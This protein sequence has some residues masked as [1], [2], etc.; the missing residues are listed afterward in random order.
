M[1]FGILGALTVWRDG[2]EV[3]VLAPK[4]RALLTVLLLD[5]DR[6]VP[7]GRLMAA[8]WGDRPPTAAGPSLHNHVMRLRR[9]LGPDG[10]RIRAVP[11]GYL[12]EVGDDNLDARLFERRC[13]AGRAAWEAGDWSAAAT[14]F[15]EGLAVWRGT[16]LDDV[17]SDVHAPEVRRLTE[18]HLQALESHADANLNLGR[19][20]ELI[21]Q[22]RALIGEHPLVEAFHGQLIRALSAAGRQAEALAAFQELRRVLVDELGTEPGPA[23]QTLHRRILTGDSMPEPGPA[24][25]ALVPAQLPSDIHDFTGR[26]T[27]AKEMRDRLSAGVEANSAVPVCTIVG[28]GGIGKTALAVHVAHRI[29]DAFPD[30]QLYVNLRG[31]DPGPVGP[32]EA[33]DGFLR[34]L[35]MAEKDIPPGQE[36]RAGRFRSLLAGRRVLV[37]LDNARDAA[38][39]RPL[40]PGSPGCAVL[41]T[42]RARL[43]GL[44]ATAQL[45]LTT[46]PVPEARALFG[47][48][49]GPDRVA[50]EPDATADVLASCA[51]LP[52]AIRIA[53]AR[54]AV[55]PTWLVRTLA[56]RLA[57]QAR[58]LD[59]LTVEDLAVRASF[60]V[61]YANLTPTRPG[62]IDPA[63]V[64]RLLGIVTLPDI[65]LAAAAALVGENANRLETTLELLVDTCLL[66]SPAPGRYGLHDLV[67]LYAAERATQEE[68]G[69]TVAG[70]VTRWVEW[71]L[72]AGTAATQL[73]NP[74]RRPIDVPSPDPRWPPPL[75]AAL[76]EAIHWSDTERPSL[77]EA[78]R[79]AA[80]HGRHDLAWRVPAIARPYYGR[81]SRWDVWFDTTRAG[82]ASARVLDDI[83]GQSLLLNS[84]GALFGLTN[85]LTE[86]EQALTE[87]VRLR[88]QLGD[89]RGVLS[90]LINLSNVYGRQGNDEQCRQT[91]SESVELARQIGVR[92]AEADALSNLGECLSRLGDHA[93]A[94][95]RLDEC[96]TIWRELADED[97]VCVALLNIGEVYLAS[98]RPELALSYLDRALP[99]AQSTA[100][101]YAEASILRARGRAL[102]ALNRPDEGR[103]A[104]TEAHRQWQTIAP[105]DAEEIRLLLDRLDRPANQETNP[106]IP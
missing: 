18:L 29:A 22:L 37:V 92:N 89:Q 58:R 81:C 6:V 14:A 41:V 62:D 86:A 44:A 51:G 13:R 34:D 104:L 31:A 33:L 8:L 2:A 85:R 79:L 87:S 38:Q 26:Q 39:V 105:G 100:D 5:A 48:I 93:G 78:T 32:G 47:A 83:F 66:E 36:A 53:G 80:A 56:D 42:S 30:G 60:E 49:V 65:G 82:L 63:R 16:P 74:H 3:P 21:P 103:A 68:T 28:P 4:L 64:F 55:R 95:A 23:L 43:P 27:D 54:L 98:A 73:I 70:A 97:G 106:N 19:H 59:E 7:V 40:L 17:P 35:G 76:P 11:G 99:L 96:L 1:R 9:L 72:A 46:L 71:T 25:A 67:R 91:L 10:A 90:T 52:L 84:L 20:R 77:V 75:F 15:D 57:D 88:R 24:M 102:I 50:A 69:A 101:R 45:D 94:L 61:S 12:I